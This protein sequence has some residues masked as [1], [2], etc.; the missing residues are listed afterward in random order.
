MSVVPVF[1]EK[2]YHCS[3]VNV[4]RVCG[5]TFSLGAVGPRKFDLLTAAAQHNV[6]FCVLWKYAIIN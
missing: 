1:K 4:E 6:L 3:G 2:P 5:P